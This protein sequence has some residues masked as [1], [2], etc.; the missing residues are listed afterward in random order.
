MRISDVCIHRPV[1][2][3]LV[4]GF[5]L[6]ASSLANCRVSSADELPTITVI[7]QYPGAS[8]DSI[9]VSIAAPLERRFATI[10]GVAS[11]TS[12][13]ADG[14]T[15]VTLGFEGRRAIDAAAPDLQSAFSAL[16][17]SLP[18]Y[19]PAPAIVASGGDR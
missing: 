4:T 13:S 10:P 12:A 7:V 16:S 14:I 3:I 6:F 5:V 9:A 15:K 17:A 2:T 8:A 11:I 1:M 19:L 18:Q